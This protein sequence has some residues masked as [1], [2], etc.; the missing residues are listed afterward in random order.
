MLIASLFKAFSQLDDPRLRRVLGLGVLGAVVAYAALV[1]AAWLLLTRVDWL[2]QAWE[3]TVV[4]VAGILSAV[5]L[6]LLFFPAL[7]T[8]VMSPMLERVADAV[9]ERHYP[10]LNWPRPQPWAEV[11]ATTLRFLLVTL[12]VNLAALPVY[13]LLLFTGLAFPIA[14][15][16]N[17]YLLGREYFELVALRRLDPPR[18]RQLYRDRLGQLWLGGIVIAFL[19]SIPVL[20]LA[21]P[22]IGA[23]FMTHVFQA[24]RRDA[25]EL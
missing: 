14:Y 22:V 8:L 12:A 17:G 23:A 1:A 5:V 11:L 4:G 3:N 16:V 21:A 20:N 25:L 2:P 9:E 24:L 10:Q 19:F 15:A 13:G 7:V 6:P 18:A